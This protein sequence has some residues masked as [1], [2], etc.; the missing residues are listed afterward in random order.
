M[1]SFCKRI[2]AYGT[3][4]EQFC[5]ALFYLFKNMQQKKRT[6]HLKSLQIEMGVE[7][8]QFQ[9]LFLIFN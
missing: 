3:V 6:T 2:N 4:V 5:I 8:N 7:P 1:F 9:T